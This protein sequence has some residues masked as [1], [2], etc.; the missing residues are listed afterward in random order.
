MTDQL[1]LVPSWFNH[2]AGG[3]EQDQAAS[4]K[5]KAHI[6]IGGH[7]CSDLRINGVE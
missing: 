5:T 2:N 3:W 4:D 7:D 1:L 6:V